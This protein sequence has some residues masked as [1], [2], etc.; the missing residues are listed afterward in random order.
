MAITTEHPTEPSKEAVPV[1]A[2]VV[3]PLGPRVRWGGVMS[4]LFVALGALMLLTTLGLAIGITVLGDPRA[5]TDET[6]SGL[7]IGAGIW[8]FITLLVAVFLG[9]MVSTKV[10]DRPDRA[11][12]VIHGTLVW[13]LFM[14]FLFWLMASGISL[15]LSGLF[16]VMRTFAQGATAAGLGAVAGGGDL[17]QRLGLD[18]PNQV[19]ARLD[20]PQTASILAN[21]TGMPTEEAQAALKDLRSRVEATQNDPAQVAAEVRNFVGQY[22]ERVK[23]RAM[24]AAATAQRGATIGSWVSFGV[25]LVTVVMSIAGAMSGTP[26]F[27]RWRQSLVRVRG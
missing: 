22:A 10:T 3:T 27:Q 26:S 4:G 16:G 1:A 25:M 24:E 11:G 20:D 17:T 12:A 6:A 14:L 19:M 5:A 13:V 18:D 2:D 15:G 23:Q 21:A 7:G 9:G 8:A